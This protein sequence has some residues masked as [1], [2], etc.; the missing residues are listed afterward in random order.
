MA[1]RIQPIQVQFDTEQQIASERGLLDRQIQAA[2]AQQFQQ[3]TI[4]R[5]NAQSVIDQQVIGDIQDQFSRSP[6]ATQQRMIDAVRAT[7]GLVDVFQ[8]NNIPVDDFRPTNPSVGEAVNTKASTEDQLISLQGQRA[9]LDRKRQQAAQPRP[10]RSGRNQGAQ[11]KRQVA[12]AD[13]QQSQ[14]GEVRRSD[15]EIFIFNG[16]EFVPVKSLSREQITDLR[17]EGS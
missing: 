1:N 8:R 3:E 2:Q 5:Q 17:T 16:D 12:E 15:G 7:P 10:Q 6:F 13:T 9:T 4:A 11:N 14:R